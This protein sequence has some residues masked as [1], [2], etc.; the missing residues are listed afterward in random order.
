MGVDRDYSKSALEKLSKAIDDYYDMNWFE[1]AGKTIKDWF[2]FGSKGK[3]DSYVQSLSK[4]K[5]SAISKVTR[6][7]TDIQSV[8][9]RYMGLFTD[10]GEEVKSYNNIIDKMSG[11]LGSGNVNKSWSFTALINSMAD[12]YMNLIEAR[13]LKIL[14]KDPKDWTDE[15]YEIMAYAYLHTS[16]PELQEKILNSFYNKQEYDYFFEKNKPQTNVAAGQEYF[17]RTDKPDLYVR[18]DA[19]AEKFQQYLDY[20]LAAAYAK[21]RQGDPNDL[22]AENQINNILCNYYNASHLLTGTG[23][24]YIWSRDESVIVVGSGGDISYQV[25]SSG[26]VVRNPDGSY[27]FSGSEQ[28]HNLKKE[29]Y[30]VATI[31]NGAAGGEYVN[32]QIDKDYESDSIGEDLKNKAIKT[33]IKTGEKFLKTGADYIIP[34]SGKVY[35]AVKEMYEAEQEAQ[36]TEN[37]FTMTDMRDYSNA[38]GVKLVVTSEGYTVLPTPASDQVIAQLQEFFQDPKN[39]KTYSDFYNSY[40]KGKTADDYTNGNVDISGMAQY[41]STAKASS[42]SG[43]NPLLS[44]L[45]GDPND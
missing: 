37:Y 7:L 15:E 31:K 23:T 2:G 12:D 36:K 19:S 26:Y 40:V 27:T 41:I 16:N 30:G 6:T 42:T 45:D 24:Q 9:T 22:D 14:E 44:I 5:A 18:D 28:I 34:G 35:D 38:L 32:S 39:Q 11:F 4:D 21:Y 3:Y 13:A 29:T 25:S 33:V 10:T 1:K 8:E 17:D 20:Y 43:T